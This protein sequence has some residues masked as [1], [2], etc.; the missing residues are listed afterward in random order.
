MHSTLADWA[1]FVR[2][3]EAGLSAW[4]AGQTPTGGLVGP[5]LVATLHTPCSPEVDGE[6]FSGPEKP[7]GY[8]MGWHCV[9]DE[10]ADGAPA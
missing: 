8:A 1:S 5:D 6:P 10:P 3:H 4:R 9:W 7:M 2:Q